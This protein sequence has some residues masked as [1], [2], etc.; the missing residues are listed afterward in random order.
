MI[1]NNQKT[2]IY[3]NSQKKFN[4]SEQNKRLITNIWIIYLD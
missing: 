4:T 2:F 1:V 3:N